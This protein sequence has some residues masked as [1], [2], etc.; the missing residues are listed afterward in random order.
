MAALGTLAGWQGGGWGMDPEAV[1]TLSGPGSGLD[2][3]AR[4]TG[5]KTTTCDKDQ[6][7]G[8]RLQKPRRNRGPGP[9][10]RGGALTR[11][12]PQRW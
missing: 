1:T 10:V 6:R 12:S 7:V 8:P 5:R 4:K 2:A 9:G 11:A 3:L